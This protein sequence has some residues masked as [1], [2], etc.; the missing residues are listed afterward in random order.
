MSGRIRFLEFD[1]FHAF[2]QFWCVQVFD[3][4]K[5]RPIDLCYAWQQW[6]MGKVTLEIQDVGIDTNFNRR[7][8][9]VDINLFERWFSFV[10]DEFFYSWNSF[11]ISAIWRLPWLLSGIS[12]KTRNFLGIAIGSNQLRKAFLSANQNL[13]FP[14]SCSV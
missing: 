4:I 9:I 3:R 7:D 6:E 10:H 11:S 2:E 13:P 12:S 5:Q 8:V 1:D 14:S